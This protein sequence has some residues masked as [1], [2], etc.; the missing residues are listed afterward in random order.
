MLNWI[1]KRCGS[2]SA[3][4]LAETAFSQCQHLNSINNSRKNFFKIR[5]VNNGNKWFENYISRNY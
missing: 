2:L 5:I 3:C 4:T 1:R